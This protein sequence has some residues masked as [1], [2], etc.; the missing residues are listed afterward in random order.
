MAKRESHMRGAF[1]RFYHP[2]YSAYLGL[3]FISQM[4]KSLMSLNSLV[5]CF[6]K[7]SIRD[8]G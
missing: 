6:L 3:E 5:W 4:G 2:Q 8:R 7:V 1:A